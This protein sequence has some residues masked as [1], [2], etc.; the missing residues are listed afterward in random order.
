MPRG[1]WSPRVLYR[2]GDLVLSSG[3]TWR[4][5]V[6]NI[7]K[8]PSANPDKWLIFAARGAIGL[9]GKQ[10]PTGPAGLAGAPGIAGPVGPQGPEGNVGA[11]AHKEFRVRSGQLARKALKVYRASLDRLAHKSRKGRV[12]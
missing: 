9:Q 5:L 4:S 11:P 2:P 3:S 8:E 12:V 1:A 7:D 10:G 6:E